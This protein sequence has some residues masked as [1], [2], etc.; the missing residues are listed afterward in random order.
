MCEAGWG[1][2]PSC[3][4]SVLG[5]D[6]TIDHILW[7]SLPAGRHAYKSTRHEH[8]AGRR[9]PTAHQKSRHKGGWVSVDGWSPRQGR[10]R[11]A[12]A[13]A[14]TVSCSALCAGRDLARG[15]DRR[16]AQKGL[17]VAPPRCQAPTLLGRS[18]RSRRWGLR[19]CR[20][21]RHCRRIWLFRPVHPLQLVDAR[22]GDK[23]VGGGQIPV[24]RRDDKGPPRPDDARGG[25]RYG[26]DHQEKRPRHP[27][28][29]NRRTATRTT[30]S[31][32]R[33]K[34]QRQ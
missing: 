3:S 27:R 15:R 4:N 17:G 13:Q 10:R 22:A 18:R 32:H 26:R 8:S 16:P 29:P 5:F 20:S 14:R 23:D 11:R 19:R 31:H 30:E 9:Q 24:D 12:I 6:Q 7:R 28:G 33:S 2:P 1:P 21:S 34:K 25:Q